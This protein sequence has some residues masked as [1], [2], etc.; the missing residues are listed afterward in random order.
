MITRPWRRVFLLGFLDWLAPF[1]ISFVIFP[2]RSSNYFLF[3]SLMSVAVVASAV[4]AG[5]VNFRPAIDVSFRE[6]VAVGLIWMLINLALDLTLFLS[7]SPMHM[8]LGLYLSQIG[9]KYLAI[10]VVLG[11]LARGRA[12]R[13]VSH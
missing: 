12:A 2:I 1:A 11:G 5:S 8:G 10:P 3:E 6:G 4:V 13:P 9:T 7:P